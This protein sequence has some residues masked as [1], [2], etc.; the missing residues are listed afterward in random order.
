MET[1]S[2]VSLPFFSSSPSP[3]APLSLVSVPFN[4]DYDKV[5]KDIFSLFNSLSSL[6]KAST[7]AFF[8]LSPDSFISR[9]KSIFIIIASRCKIYNII[10]LNF[11]NSFKFY[12]K[13]L[14]IQIFSIFLFHNRIIS[15]Q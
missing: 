10:M 12:E 6:A 13:F 11:Y 9:I 5:K 7:T 15:E 1:L 14:F 4:E 2:S 3:P 8:P